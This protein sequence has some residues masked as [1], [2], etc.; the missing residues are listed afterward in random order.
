MTRGC[1]SIIDPNGSSV[2]SPQ[3]RQATVRVE[4]G[5]RSAERNVEGARWRRSVAVAV[6]MAVLVGPRTRCDLGCHL[7]GRRWSADPDDVFA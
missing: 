5:A 7:S 4:R 3:A 6:A 2:D 1:P